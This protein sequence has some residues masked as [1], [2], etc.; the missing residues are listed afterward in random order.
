M[1]TIT[2]EPA[3]QSRFAD[4]EHALTGGGD[5]ASCQCQWWLMTSREFDST[6]REEREERLRI[7]LGTT[8]SP[9]L[10]AYVDGVAAGFV[11]VGPRI[12]QP[13]LAR[14]RN[15]Q[16][17]PS[18][19][20]EPDVWAVTC[21]V[22]R[23]EYRNQGLNRR[24]LDAAIVHARENGARVLEA[25]PGDTSAKK[26]PANDLFV[27]AL[28]TFVAAGFHEVADRPKPHRTIVQLDL[29]QG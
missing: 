18:P 23:R 15:F 1:S 17:S 5:G 13:R 25:Y 14:T 4:T 27:G 6:S 9:A 20:D 28:S 22:V 29:T 24:L 19:W 3:T 7:E 12:K 10:I 8:P 26:I 21:F 11:R 2:I 16:G